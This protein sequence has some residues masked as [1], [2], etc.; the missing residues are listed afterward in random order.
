MKEKILHLQISYLKTL[1]KEI[2]LVLLLCAIYSINKLERNSIICVSKKNYNGCHMGPY[3]LLQG[4]CYQGTSLSSLLEQLP[5]CA[6]APY[7]CPLSL[8][9]T[10]L[11]FSLSKHFTLG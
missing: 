8:S 3:F 6:Q 11:V 2:L 5:R 4:R 10:Y 9:S 1:L 7:V